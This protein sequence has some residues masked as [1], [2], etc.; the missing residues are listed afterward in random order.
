MH[1][2]G[3]MLILTLTMTLTIAQNLHLPSHGKQ[4][5]RVTVVITQTTLLSGE[6]TT[7]CCDVV[8][9]GVECSL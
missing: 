4:Y 2:R 3:R 1:V 7:L 5:V 9:L 6:V 8:K